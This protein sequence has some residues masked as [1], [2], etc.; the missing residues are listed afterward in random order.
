MIE[1]VTK[2]VVF[3][4]GLDKHILTFP[5]YVTHREFADSL[6]ELSDGMLYPISG[7]FI[8]NGECVGESVSLRLKSRGE[9]DTSLL[10]KL[11]VTV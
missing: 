11:L 8:E 4:D 7:G 1:D 9:K 3:D 10:H 2:Y 6:K 5:A